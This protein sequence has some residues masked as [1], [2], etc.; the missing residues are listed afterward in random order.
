MTAPGDMEKA[1]EIVGN[2]HG[3]WDYA[4]GSLIRAVETAL[5][6]ARA[7][8]RGTRDKLWVQALMNVSD[9]LSVKQC[10]LIADEVVRLDAIRK[11]SP[12]DR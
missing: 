11:D 1:R 5:T 12:N 8:E 10:K 2:L 3:D 4:H 9:A 6:Q 7:E